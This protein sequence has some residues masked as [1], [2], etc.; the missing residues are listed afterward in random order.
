MIFMMNARN[1]LALL[2]AAAPLAAFAVTGDEA[3]PPPAAAAKPAVDADNLF[4]NSIV[5]K[6]NGVS[7]SRNQLDDEIVRIKAMLAA[8][9]RTPSPEDSASL[10]EQVL[11][12][13]IGK[14]LVLAKATDADKAKGREDFDKAIQRLKTSQN[15][16]DEQY[17]QRLARQLSLLNVTRTDWEKQ[18]T[19]QATIPIV[20]ERELHINTTDADVKKF[21]DDNSAKFEQP[22]MVRAAHILLMTSDPTTHAELSDDKKAEKKKQIQDILKRA[23]A[24]EDFGKLA[25]EFS[26][27]PGSK[28]NGGEYKFPRGQM[29]PE[30]ESAA[31]SLNTNQIS[32]VITTQFGY[33]I[34][35]LYEKFPAKKLALTDTVPGGDVTVAQA[36]KESLTQ[37]ALQK[38]AVDYIAKLRKDAAVQILDEKL[39]A[40]AEARQK[41]MDGAKDSSGPSTSTSSPAAK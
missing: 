11:D 40:T 26:E 7:I 34:I 36:I 33:H 2:V 8:Q 10:D 22:E 32:D 35:K 12:S 29:V 31:F 30:F 39:K 38:Q 18:S 6:G 24:G 9:G 16:T 25:K 37:Q 3:A 23:R 19:E 28:D 15:L 14:Q 17:N 27:D 1:W 41:L 5:A 13:L 4:T 21:Y 20:L